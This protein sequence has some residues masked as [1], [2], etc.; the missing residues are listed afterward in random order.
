MASLFARLMND[1]VQEIISV[2]D[3]MHLAQLYTPALVATMVPADDTAKEGYIYD[4][5]AKTFTAPAVPSPTPTDILNTKISAGIQ[6]VSTGTPSLN[7]T[8]PL[9]DGSEAQLTGIL[10]GIAAGLGLPFGASTVPWAD[11]NG[12]PHNFTA[13]QMKAFGSAV[14]DYRYGLQ[15]TWN[16]LNNGQSATWPSLPVTIA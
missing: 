1:V 2:A 13:D 16:L 5:E 6:I 12:V 10:V 14:R 9:G 11:I 3:G 4:P 15:V 8:Y 7:G